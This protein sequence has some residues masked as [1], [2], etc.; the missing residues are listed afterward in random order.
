MEWRMKK[1]L[2]VALVLII[3]ITAL[4]IG[5]CA[6]FKFQTQDLCIQVSET[7]K[8]NGSLNRIKNEANRYKFEPSGNGVNQVLFFKL[9]T[10]PGLCIV[11]LKNGK[12]I[13]AKYSVSP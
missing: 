3:I 7:I 8:N 9:Y 6:Y 1:A 5:L 11:T 10:I 12:P 4:I 2:K 13:S